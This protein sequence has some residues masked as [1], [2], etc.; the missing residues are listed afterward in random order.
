LKKS[1]GE[2]RI[3]VKKK[4]AKQSERGSL[5]EEMGEEEEKGGRRSRG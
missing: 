3:P 5:E 1:R 4:V 2:N